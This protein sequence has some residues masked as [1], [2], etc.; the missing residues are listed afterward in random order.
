MSTYTNYMLIFTIRKNNINERKYITAR[1][2]ELTNIRENIYIARLQ[3]TDACAR[4]GNSVS[5]IMAKII[6]TITKIWQE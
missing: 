2:K 1:C 4:I 3:I 6:I 5:I